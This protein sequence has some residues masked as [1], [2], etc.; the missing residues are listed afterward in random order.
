M[1]IIKQIPK[2]E[3]CGI[4][5]SGGEPFEQAEE[6]AIFL[7]QAGQNQLNRLVYT[8]FTCEELAAKNDITINKCLSFIDILIDGHYTK[9]VPS[10]LPWTG[11]GNQR[12]LQLK[13]G[14]IINVYEKSDFDGINEN[15]G[16]IIIG[17]NGSIIAT[18]IFNSSPLL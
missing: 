17:F 4:T 14:K 15:E 3:V 10:V 1:E 5:V 7:E 6:L 2:E 9:D 16:E 18:G 11:S 13:H 12:I 8:G